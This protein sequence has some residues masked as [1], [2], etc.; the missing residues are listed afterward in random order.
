MLGEI[1]WLYSRIVDRCPAMPTSEMGQNQKSSIRAN[2][3]RFA[4]DSGHCGM[5]LGRP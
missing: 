3:F 2:V 4:P 1:E 5:Q